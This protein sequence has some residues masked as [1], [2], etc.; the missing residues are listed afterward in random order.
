MQ[1]SEINELGDAAVRSQVERILQSK[2]FEGSAVHRRLLQFLADHALAGDAA[3]LKEYTLA[4]DALGRPT[5]YAPRH[6]SVVRIQ[7]GRLRSKLTEYYQAE[8]LQDPIRISL[9]KGGFQLFF[10]EALA[11]SAAPAPAARM[12]LAVVLLSAALLLAAGYSAWATLRLNAALG[13]A[14][15]SD[16]AWTPE[17]REFWEPFLASKRPLAICFGTPIFLN[18]PSH[19]FAR[20]SGTNTWADVQ[21][22]PAY[23]AM[24]RALPND[25][26]LPW[27]P[28]TGVGEA[29]GGFLLGKLLGTRR[30]GIYVTRSN[31][32]SWQEISDTNVI[33]LGPPKFNAQ[34]RDIPVK[35]EI[36]VEPQGIRVLNPKPGESAFYQDYF[37]EGPEPNG[38]THALI[39]CTP[40]ISGNGLLLIFAG[41]ASP[42]TLSATQWLTQ[43]NRA[44]ELYGRMRLPSGRLPRYYQILIQ[45]DFKNGVPVSSSYVL[46]R[47]LQTRQPE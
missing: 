27:Y 12:R 3:Q 38:S 20:F 45:V 19:I 24:A 37:Q 30:A 17:L 32:L 13:S 15:A 42:D 4:V 18:Y 23:A 36:Q 39:S 22:S 2:S 7:V 35:Q 47:E 43:P 34:L 44:R 31:L 8:G 40:G 16:E 29:T 9:P 33:F 21:A 46:H 10:E 1:H 28:F 11:A 26:P 5:T 14:S 25:K 6:E 41:N